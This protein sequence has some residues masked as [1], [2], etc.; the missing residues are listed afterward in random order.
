M[1]ARN[2]DRCWSPRCEELAAYADGE[3]D[4]WEGGPALKQRIEEWLADHPEGL[5]EVESLRRLGRLWMSSAA[6]EPHEAWPELAGRIHKRL[7][8]APARPSPRKARKGFWAAAFLALA[9][10]ILLAFLNLNQPGPD[11]NKSKEPEKKPA[12]VA[13]EPFPVATAEEV[14]I[15]HVDG[16]DTD[17]LVVGDLPVKGPLLLAEPGD[18]KLKSVD[19]AEDPA[20]VG[21]HMNEETPPV[22]WTPVPTEGSK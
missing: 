10:A 5:A 18:V 8:E 15:L 1:M 14:E 20:K 16:D 11:D 7:H 13:V 22:I 9:A 21:V 6:P 17:A 19:S 2:D 3:L 12:A 4:H